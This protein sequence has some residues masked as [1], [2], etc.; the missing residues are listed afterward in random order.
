MNEFTEIV[1]RFFTM[2]QSV[3]EGKCGVLLGDRCAIAVDAGMH[4]EEGQALADFIREKGYEPNRF[5]LTH[6]HHDHVMGSEPFREG[7]VY[8]HALSAEVLNERIQTYPERFGIDPEEIR[9]R[10][11]WPNVSFERRMIMDLGN[12][13]LEL[14]HTPGHS[15][16][17]ISLYIPEHRLLY[18]S[19]TIVTCIVPAIFLGDGRVLQKTLSKLMDVDVEILVAGHGPVLYGRERIKDWIL[20]VQKYIA[21]VRERVRILLRQGQVAAEIPKQIIFDD[22]APKALRKDQHNMEGRHHDMVAKIVNEESEDRTR[23]ESSILSD[24]RSRS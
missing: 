6:A 11:A 22:F 23:T 7:E 20:T 1:P 8:A 9:P 12:L 21:G 10:L 13:E 16:D 14:F 19:D 4:R 24:Q 5:I 18:A 17:S 3:V 2:E 15:P